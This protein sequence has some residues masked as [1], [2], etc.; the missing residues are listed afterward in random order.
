MADRKPTTLRGARNFV[1]S[2]TLL[3]K[4]PRCG[5]DALYLAIRLVWSFPQGRL[6]GTKARKRTWHTRL[7]HSPG[8]SGLSSQLRESPHPQAPEPDVIVTVLR[9]VPVTVRN[10]DV[11]RIIVPRTAAQRFQIG[12]A[13][14]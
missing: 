10:A 12:R 2:A 8:S 3:S 4:L 1:R 9:F 11:R 14:V 13:H 6:A 5:T 7:D